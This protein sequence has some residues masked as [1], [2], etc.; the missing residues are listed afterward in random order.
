MA[1]PDPTARTGLAVSLGVGLTEMDAAGGDFET[2]LER[3][4][5]NRRKIAGAGEVKGS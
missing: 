4:P 1:S 2:G 5:G 3:G